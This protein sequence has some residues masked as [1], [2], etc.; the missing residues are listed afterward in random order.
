M[1]HNLN[2]MSDTIS[3]IDF[4]NGSIQ[5][6]TRIIPKPDNE[7]NNNRLILKSLL[8]SDGSNSNA[9][10]L[11]QKILKDKF[12]KAFGLGKDIRKKS[13]NIGSIIYSEYSCLLD[14]PEYMQ[15]LDRLIIV[16]HPYNINKELLD[17]FT[18]KYMI[19]YHILDEWD[20]YYPGNSHMILFEITPLSV[21]LIKN[22]TMIKSLWDVNKSLF[23]DNISN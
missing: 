17:K 23:T 19:H 5:S 15:L 21:L 1:I 12:I 16:S 8:S 7:Y 14:H 11:T 18:S 6:R 2:Y 3:P 4:V 10:I 20:Y 13:S 22:P 9:I